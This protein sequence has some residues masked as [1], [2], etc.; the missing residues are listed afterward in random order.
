MRDSNLIKLAFVL[1][2]AG[3]IGLF[4]TFGLGFSDL[5]DDIEF[6]KQWE[7]SADS[8]NEISILSSY[9][10]DVQFVPS[11]NERSTIHIEGKAAE[12][13]VSKIGQ[14]VINGQTLVLDL[15]KDRFQLDLLFNLEWLSKQTVTIALAEGTTLQ[16]LYTETGS[17]RITIRNAD[18]QKA[19]VRTSSGSIHV[20]GLKAQDNIRLHASSGAIRAEQLTGSEIE[21]RTSSGSIHLDSVE[22]NSISVESSSGAIKATEVQGDTAFRSSSGSINLEHSGGTLQ[23]SSSSGSVRVTQSDVSETSVSTTSGSVRLTVPRSFNGYYEARSNSGTM[24]VPESKRQSEQYI[25]VQT[26]SGSIRIIEN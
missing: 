14:T 1:V 18:V 10:V 2:G 26:S 19:E 25:N 7:F 23:T 13:V 5:N 21:L 11:T 16:S 8:F 9:M 12:E 24:R 22:G 3:L 4:L 15:K 20:N 6:E 17:N